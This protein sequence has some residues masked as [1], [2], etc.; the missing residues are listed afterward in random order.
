M[1]RFLVLF[2][3]LAGGLIA[4]DSGTGPQPS[5]PTG[6]PVSVPTGTLVSVATDTATVV[7]L[8]P[9]VATDSAKNTQVVTYRIHVATSVALTGEPTWTPGAPP[10]LPTL[11]PIL[12]IVGGCPSPNSRGFQCYNMWRGYHAGHLMEVRVGRQGSDEDPTQGE[13]V[14]LTRGTRETYFGPGKTGAFDIVSL[15]GDLVTVTAVESPHHEIFIFNLQTHQWTTIS[16]LPGGSP[17]AS[18]LP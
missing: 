16:P 10:D 11:T 6:T 2:L 12:G 3:L 18:P 5:V 14:V 8:P 9:A 15:D 13:I 4:C 1:L 7:S 17:T